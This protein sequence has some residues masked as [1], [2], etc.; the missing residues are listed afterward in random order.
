VRMFF[1]YNRYKSW[2]Q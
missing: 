1:R 2:I